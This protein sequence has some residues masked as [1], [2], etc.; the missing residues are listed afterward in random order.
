MGVDL[1][2]Y[3]LPR[4]SLPLAYLVGP[5]LPRILFISF[6]VYRQLFMQSQPIVA[7]SML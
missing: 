7:R 4:S 1:S 6:A 3:V 2:G 5:K